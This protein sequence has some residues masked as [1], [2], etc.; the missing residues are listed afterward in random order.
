VEGLGIQQKK[1]PRRASVPDEIRTKHNLSESQKYYH[2]CQLAQLANL[3]Y[4]H[5]TRM[6][7]QKSNFELFAV[8]V[9]VGMCIFSVGGEW[10]IFSQKEHF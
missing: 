2:L 1:L 3:Q 9:Y 10:K 6:Y 5:A 4:C 7:S 8:Q